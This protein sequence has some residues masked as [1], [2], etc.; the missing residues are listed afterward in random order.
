MTAPER[1]EHV[2]RSGCPMSNNGG[3]RARRVFG[4]EFRAGPV[5]LILGAGKSAGAVA[6]KL[7][8]SESAL[9]VLSARMQ[10]DRTRGKSGRSQ[11]GAIRSGNLG[12]R[13]L[14][15]AA[16]PKSRHSS[17]HG[18]CPSELLLAP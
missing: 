9:L 7:D 12:S 1:S 17:P 18:L 8:L 11:A 14:T 2:A 5:R 3:R 13:S 10:A 6:R 16:E 4:E 15:R